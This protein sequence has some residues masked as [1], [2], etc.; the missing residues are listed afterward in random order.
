[1]T[2]SRQKTITWSLACICVL[3]FT[4]IALP[5]RIRPPS[6]MSR[7]RLRSLMGFCVMGA[8]SLTMSS[9]TSASDM[10]RHLTLEESSSSNIWKMRLAVSN[11]LLITDPMSRLSAVGM[12]DRFST[13][14]TVFT[15]PKRLADRQARILVSA[16]SVSAT[17]ASVPVFHQNLSE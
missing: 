11:F 13:S 6:V 12:N 1:M 15:A 8:F 4:I 16:L 10:A 14:A 5:S 17:N 2:V 7:G 3:P 9:A